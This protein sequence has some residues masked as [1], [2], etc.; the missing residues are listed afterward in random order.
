M[1]AEPHKWRVATI[2][3]DVR[4][5]PSGEVV[6]T[7]DGKYEASTA[8]GALSKAGLVL[9]GALAQVPGFRWGDA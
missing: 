7:A 2:A 3:L 9:E 6:W 4:R 1:P 5:D 8:A